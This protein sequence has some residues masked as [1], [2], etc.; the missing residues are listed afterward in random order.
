MVGFTTGFGTV[1]PATD[2]SDAGPRGEGDIYRVFGTGTLPTG[3]SG[4]SPR[5]ETVIQPAL[6]HVAPAHESIGTIPC[7]APITPRLKQ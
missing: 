5:G 4:A 7:A 6:R 2:S 1:I 3:T